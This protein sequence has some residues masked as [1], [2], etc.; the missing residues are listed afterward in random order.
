MRS[1]H[2][3]RADKSELVCFGDLTAGTLQLACFSSLPFRQTIAGDSMLQCRNK[4][5]VGN[6]KFCNSN[7]GS[8]V[9]IRE[10]QISKK[11]I[12]GKILIRRNQV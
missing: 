6:R 12:G 10:R 4:N 3:R 5:V 1:F 8:T 2:R 9:R 11:E 7:S